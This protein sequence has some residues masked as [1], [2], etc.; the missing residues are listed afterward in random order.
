MK[1]LLLIFTLLLF[2]VSIYSQTK[3]LPKTETKGDLQEITLYYENGAIMQHGFYTKEGKLH[4]SWESYNLD[5][6]RKCLAT[7]NYGVKIGTW[8]YWND[9]KVT[10]IEYDNN[11]VVKIEEFEV[12]D[13]PKTSY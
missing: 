5:G 4:A 10:K 9:N 11:K 8:T 7:Y 12:K 1:K 6:T 2:S 13:L 3:Y